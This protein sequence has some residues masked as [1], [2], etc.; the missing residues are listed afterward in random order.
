[1]YFRRK[2]QVTDL[3][4]INSIR[5]DRDS[6]DGKSESTGGLAGLQEKYVTCS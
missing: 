3:Q 5:T 6:F 4:H 1:M 2:K